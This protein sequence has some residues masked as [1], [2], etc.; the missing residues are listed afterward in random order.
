LLES[1]PNLKKK[2]E[3]EVIKKIKESIQ[4]DEIVRVCDEGIS[5]AI[6]GKLARVGRLME[7][8]P[9]TYRVVKTRD[10][11]SETLHYF[12]PQF[13]KDGVEL[14]PSKVVEWIVRTYN[15]CHREEI[16]ISWDAR[17]I[18]KGGLSG[19]R[20]QTAVYLSPK[21]KGIKLSR[22]HC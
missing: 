18:R 13:T 10:Q 21:K 8:L 11:L 19:E 17:Q 22:T 14:D 12:L 16:C 9:T 4:P 1:H 20:T 7:I 15:L 2:L 3:N 6:Y 5:T